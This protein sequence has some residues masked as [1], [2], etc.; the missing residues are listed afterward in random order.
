MLLRKLILAAAA[1]GSLAV[2]A[3]AQR[4]GTVCVTP[5]GWCQLPGVFQPGSACFC[6]TANGTF[7]GIVR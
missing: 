7:H 4:P 6:A 2:P 1:C 3:A 5:Y